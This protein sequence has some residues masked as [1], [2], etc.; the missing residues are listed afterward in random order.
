MGVIPV[1]TPR[2]QL[3]HPDRWLCRLRQGPGQGLAAASAEATA[4]GAGRLS[5]RNIRGPGPLFT[6]GFE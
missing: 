6:G 2:S 3:S 1:F 4:H 5:G